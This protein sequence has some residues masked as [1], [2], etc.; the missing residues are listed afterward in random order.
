MADA[1]LAGGVYA[2]APQM[3]TVL[4]NYMVGFG[5]RSI[6][7]QSQARSAP[8]QPAYD[9]CILNPVTTY[10]NRADVQRALHANVSGTLPGPWAYCSDAVLYGYSSVDSATSMIPVYQQLLRAGGL[11]MLIYSVDVDSVIPLLGTRLWIDSLKLTVTDPWRTW[12]STTGQVGGWTTGYAQNFRFATVRGAGHMV[13]YTQ[14]ERALYLFSN[15][16]QGK[17]P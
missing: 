12:T 10:L 3:T 1:C 14:P 9:P 7:H 11:K 16:I 8:A 5:Y 4:G 2:E 15:W 6:A 17:A 13:P